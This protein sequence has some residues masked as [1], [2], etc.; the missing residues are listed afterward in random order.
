LIGVDHGPL[1]FGSICAHGHADA[2]S[3][4]LFLEGQ[5][6]FVDPGTYLYHCDLESRNEFRKTRN[7]N[8]VCIEGRDQSEMLGAFLWGRKANAELISF[9]EKDGS[10]RLEMRHDGYKPDYHIRI[11]EFDGYR[12]LIIRD[13][14]SDTSE[15]EVNF[16]LV[17]D[18]D[19]KIETRCDEINDHRKNIKKSQGCCSYKYGVKKEIQIITAK[20]VRVVNTKIILDSANGTNQTICIERI[21]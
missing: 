7:H 15:A 3:F 21:L 2:L 4:Q 17:A 14:L 6:V 11:L 16:L 9:E 1:G 12:T 10:V 13:E 19:I 18:I 5:P 20:F 8:T